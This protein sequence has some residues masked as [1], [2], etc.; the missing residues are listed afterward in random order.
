MKPG[1]VGQG[2]RQ[3]GDSPRCPLTSSRQDIPAVQDSDLLQGKIVESVSHYA[4]DYQ[5]LKPTT[6][7]RFMVPFSSPL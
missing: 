4:Q 3:A 5:I 2:D 7:D 6:R 1:A